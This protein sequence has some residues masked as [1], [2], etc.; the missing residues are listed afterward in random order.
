ML[1]FTIFLLSFFS[2]ASSSHPAVCKSY[3]HLADWRISFFFLI[4]IPHF[5]F[6]RGDLVAS[7]LSEEPSVLYS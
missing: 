3:G 1:L 7:A 6:L 2:L 5:T 4:S